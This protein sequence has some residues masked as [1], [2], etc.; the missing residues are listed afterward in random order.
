MPSFIRLLRPSSTT[1]QWA[2]P[3][4]ISNSASSGE[5]DGADMASGISSVRIK[6]SEFRLRV[7]A[8]KILSWDYASMSGIS[9]LRNWE[10]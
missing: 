8:D 1:G 10:I 7:V 4:A 3:V 6:N 2:Q 5:V 9:L